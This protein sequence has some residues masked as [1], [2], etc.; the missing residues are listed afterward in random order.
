MKKTVV[1]TGANGDIG[2]SIV[3]RLCADGYQVIA[4]C[5]DTR[6]EDKVR[7]LPDTEVHIVDFLAPKELENVCVSIKKKHPTLYGIVNNA[8]IYRM[9]RIETY[10]PELWNQVLMINL[11]APFLLIQQLLSTLEDGGR[12]VNMSS[13]G[14]HLGSRDPGYSA[15]KAGLIG[16]TKSLARAVGSRH[17]TVNAVA[18]GTID[19]QMSRRMSDADRQKNALNSLL[20]RLG[21]PS[22]VS[23]IVAFLLSSDASY[24]TGCTI[25]INGGLYIR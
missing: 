7:S 13:T 23:G 10:T 20:G 6:N 3:K 15:S 5:G 1:V 17:I 4:L 24:M 2:F 11:T 21:E 18:P 12:I 22:D 19:T 9:E 14:A 8:G 16:L 25:D